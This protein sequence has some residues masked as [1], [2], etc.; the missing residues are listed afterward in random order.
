MSRRLAFPL[1]LLLVVLGQVLGAWKQP[2]RRTASRQTLPVDSGLDRE[3]DA[4]VDGLRRAQD[5]TGNANGIAGGAAHLIKSGWVIRE[6]TIWARHADAGATPDTTVLWSAAGDVNAAASAPGLDNRHH[7]VNAYLE[8]FRPFATANLWVPLYTISR[9]KTYEFDH[10]SVTGYRERW[11]TSREAFY[12][13]RGDCEDHA[14]ALADWLISMGE[15]ARVVLGKL[16]DEG[17]A[18]VALFRD[19][20]VYVLEATQKYRRQGPQQLR[21]AAMLPSYHPSMMFNREFFWFNTG[22]ELTVDYTGDAWEKKS[23]YRAP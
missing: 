11:Q 1:A 7:F 2:E 8:D 16:R 9:V 17:H 4:A 20:N 10:A 15:D 13:A 14:I 6:S 5:A 18:W 23:A 22:S 3:V 21:L 12:Y 19:D